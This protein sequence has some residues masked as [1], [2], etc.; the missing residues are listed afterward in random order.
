MTSWS[1]M[2]CLVFFGSQSSRHRDGQ[3]YIRALSDTE[4]ISNQFLR[5][6]MFLI[7][8]FES[9]VGRYYG[10]STPGAVLCAQLDYKLAVSIP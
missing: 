9:T 7:A 6:V 3:N 4:K 5:H 2:L 10:S 1:L 8:E